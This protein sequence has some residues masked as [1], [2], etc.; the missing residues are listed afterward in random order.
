MSMD[1]SIIEVESIWGVNTR[2]RLVSHQ[3]ASSTLAVLFPGQ[4]YGCD[5]PLLWYSRKAALLAGCDTLSLEYGYQVV[6][7][8]PTRDQ[9]PHLVEEAMSSVKQALQ[10]THRRLL[11]I[12]KS[13]GTV[14]AGEVATRFTN[15]PTSHLFLTPISS[16]LPHLRRAK[17][18]VVTGTAD[19]Q[20]DQE[21]RTQAR[22]AGALTV[23]EVPYAEHSLELDEDLPASLEILRQ[24]CEICTRLAKSADS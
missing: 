19:Q 16:T 20:F 6:R 7:T 17:G 14:V 21:C 15:L 22:A 1:R 24:V 3:S 23:V 11:F 18:V 2:N 9:F 4:N 10:P 12:S 8:S 5:L 13:L